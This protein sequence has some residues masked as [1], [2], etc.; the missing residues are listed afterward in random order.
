MT[1]SI[2]DY[3]R[4]VTGL[5]DPLRPFRRFLSRAFGWN[6]LTSQIATRTIPP[7]MKRYFWF[8]G[9]SGHPGAF[10]L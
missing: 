8:F 6:A 3:R 5:N 4:L 9:T 1:I 7:T 10:A 2:D